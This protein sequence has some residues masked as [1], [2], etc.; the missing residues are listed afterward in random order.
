MFRNLRLQGISF[1]LLFS[2][3]TAWHLRPPFAVF[4]FC[5]M[6]VYTLWFQTL[7]R[8]FFEISCVICV[9]ALATDV[10]IHRDI[11]ASFSYIAAFAV[12]L[13]LS[14]AIQRIDHRGYRL[15]ALITILVLGFTF[16]LESP[17]SQVNLRHGL[18]LFSFFWA[19]SFFTLFVDTIQRYRRTAD[20]PAVYMVP[21]FLIGLLPVGSRFF[22][23]SFATGDNEL[24]STQKSGLILATKLSA[25]FF[26]LKL[27]SS[28]LLL[29][30]SNFLSEALSTIS[31]TKEVPERI[32]SFYT[33]LGTRPPATSILTYYTISTLSLIR[34][35][36]TYG[37]AVAIARMFGFALPLVPYRWRRVDNISK[38]YG[39]ILFY[40]NRM[41]VDAFF[42]PS[43]RIVSKHFSGESARRIVTFFSVAIGG[44]FAHIVFSGRVLSE[45][46][47]TVDLL[48][49]FSA[50][51]VYATTLAFALSV[52][53]FFYSKTEPESTSPLLLCAR[54]FWIF[55]LYTAII[56]I[57]IQ[58]LVR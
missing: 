55:S 40:Y 22:V 3:L 38:F 7:R 35:L 58:L 13:I 30:H 42:I 18:W 46:R 20:S 50:F 8:Y 56:Y 36:A 6:L 10:Y 29:Q 47:S 19:S 45:F 53:R 37:L 44:T 14:T 12:F 24:L 31:T 5:G 26:L 21:W 34:F 16:F 33:S 39:N 27:L 51:S 52:S 49:H 28:L 41:L 23:K 4:L 57:N 43:F 2:L 11:G 9:G 1:V 25:I 17:K 32:L 48:A 54:L 15:S